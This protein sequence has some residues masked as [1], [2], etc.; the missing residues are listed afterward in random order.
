VFRKHITT[1][2]RYGGI[3]GVTSLTRHPVENMELLNKI[4]GEQKGFKIISSP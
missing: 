2:S 3:T 4:I 1:G